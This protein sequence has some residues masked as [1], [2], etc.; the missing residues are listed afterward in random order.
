MH[1][2][3]ARAILFAISSPTAEIVSECFRQ[4]GVSTV[5]DDDPTGARLLREKFEACVV[6]LDDPEAMHLIS[7]ARTSRSNQR[8][9]VYGLASSAAQALKYS[10]VGVNA[11]IDIPVNRTAAMK[12][13]RASHLLVLN[14]LRRYARV[15]IVTP[16]KLETDAR[17]FDAM[18]VEISAGGMSLRTDRSALMHSNLT[19]TCVL[20]PAT[21][22]KI[23]AQVAWVLAQDQR[24][25]VRFDPSDA[26][27]ARVK[28]WVDRYLEIG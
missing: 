10:K 11:I 7:A 12:V 15:P 8:I 16:A 25:G 20:P 22:L 21:D 2:P 24:F 26:Q 17:T 18:T 23:R 13:V 28:Q 14:E 27:R 6:S 19:I 1:K 9:L 3:A 4:F 5:L